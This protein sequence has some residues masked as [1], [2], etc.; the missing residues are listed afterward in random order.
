MTDKEIKDLARASSGP[1]LKFYGDPQNEEDFKKWLLCVEKR[2][3]EP[4]GGD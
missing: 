1:I 3:R 4:P 2:R